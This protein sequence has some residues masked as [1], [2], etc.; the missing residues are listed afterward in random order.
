MNSRRS[1]AKVKKSL[2]SIIAL[3]AML[4]FA[5]TGLSE[6][7]FVDNRETDKVYP[8]R[9]NLRAEPSANGAILGLYYTG[10]QVESLGV[11]G[12]YTKVSIGGV[13]GYMANEY[14]IT[15]EEAVS[16]YGEDSGFGTCRQGQVDL[17]GLWQSKQDLLETTDLQS[18]SLL[19][20]HDG[21]S[22]EVV[23]ILGED[24]A[25][26]AAPGETEK[27]YGYVPLNTLIDVLP[28]RVLIVAANKA[29]S[30]TVLYNAANDRAKEIMSLKNGTPCLALFGRK[31]GNWVKVR[32]GGVSGWIKYTQAGN[33]V[34]LMDGQARSTVPYYPLVMQTKTDALLCSVCGDTT[35]TYMTLGEGMKV[36]VLAELENYVYV[37]TLEGGAGAYDCG[38]YGYM[39][40]ADLSLS[41]S[42]GGAGIAQ[43]DDGDL[44]VLLMKEPDAQSDMLGALIA[45]AQVY[46]VDFTQTDYVQVKLGDVT[47]YVLKQQI[48]ALGEGG[49]MASDRIPQRATL[50]ENASLMSEPS[51]GSEEL[52]SV[53]QGER[54][55]VLAKFGDWAYVKAGDTADLGQSDERM[56]FIEISKLNTPA[57]TTHLTAF[58]NEDKINLRAEGS[59]DEE[60]V[61]RVRLGERLRVADYGTDW[62]CVVTPD[63]KRGYVM[64]SYLEFE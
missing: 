59:R 4:L 6:T 41:Q 24:W 7:L 16:R 5:C 14:L 20:L 58:V 12:N 61:G 27:V 26:I 34:S 10:A 29:D 46:I 50:F 28:Y 31:E 64:T 52:A 51:D 32:V 36:E 63:G 62:S 33:L 3:C 47:G 55:Y 44:P 9:L 30:R 43:A 60:I 49:E 39:A 2:I 1:V 57:S 18:E 22:I 11:E 35:S 21:D 38:D 15:A 13:T 8:E 48:R 17:G 45:G 37:R 23:G 25:Y 42:A 54:V 40:L 56:G 53:N 19:E